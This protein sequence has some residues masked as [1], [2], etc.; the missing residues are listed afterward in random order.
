MHQ[1]SPT[2]PGLRFWCKILK[3]CTVKP[4]IEDGANTSGACYSTRPLRVH[5]RLTDVTE[6]ARVQCDLVAGNGLVAANARGSWGWL[7]VALQHGAAD[8]RR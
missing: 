7:A 3:I 8:F 5:R 1:K 6:A 2:I 4:I